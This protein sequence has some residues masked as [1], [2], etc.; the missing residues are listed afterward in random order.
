MH[1]LYHSSLLKVVD[2]LP[3]LGSILSRED[4]LTLSGTRDPHFRRLI[5]IAVG[6]FANPIQQLIALYT[7]VFHIEQ[8]CR[9]TG[10]SI[11]T[12]WSRIEE[13]FDN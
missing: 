9:S 10:L 5:H 1:T 4:Q 2:G 3:K 6:P 7:I 12:I 13:F 11:F 8:N